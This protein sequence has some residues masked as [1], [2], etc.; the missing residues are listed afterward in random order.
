MTNGVLAELGQ[1]ALPAGKYTQLRLVLAAN[2]GSHPLAN[3]VVP[4]GSAETAL[5][6]A[7]RAADRASS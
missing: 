4:T 6:H 1:T 3:S 5:D 2:D 7:E